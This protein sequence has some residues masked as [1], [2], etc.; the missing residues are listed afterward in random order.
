LESKTNKDV[1]VCLHPKNPENNC[2]EDYRG[3]KA[4]K[5]Q[6]QSYIARASLVLFHDTTAIISAFMYKKEV[7]HLVGSI[8]NDFQKNLFDQYDKFK[9]NKVDFMSDTELEK[10]IQNDEISL[11]RSVIDE[12]IENNVVASGRK[13]ETG[14][15]QI[16]NDLESRYGLSRKLKSSN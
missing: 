8:F 6:T 10:V 13:N 16:I 11:D 9:I 7:V 4:V 14:Y 12:F 1:V 5:N 3:R 15:S 2:I